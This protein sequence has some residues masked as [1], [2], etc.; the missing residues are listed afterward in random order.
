MIF[1]SGIISASLNETYICLILKKV[2]SK[3]TS[4]YRPISLIPCAY[5]IIARVL[6]NHLKQFLPFTIAASQLAFVANRQILD[7]L[8]RAN[9]LIDDWFF[10]KNAGLVLKLDHEEVSNTMGWEFFDV[11]HLCFRQKVL[12]LFGGFR[13]EVASQVPTI[14]SLLVV[15][16]KERSYLL[17]VFTNRTLYHLSSSFIR[18]LSIF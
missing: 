7:A 5:K 15:V 11:V 14:L 16:V 4:D 8:L 17:V 1:F 10:Y 9:E 3:S 2:A 13:F 6:S 12:A 18:E